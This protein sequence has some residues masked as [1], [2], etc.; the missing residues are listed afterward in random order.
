MTV[1]DPSS[2][3]ANEAQVPT[4]LP[5]QIK[6]GDILLLMIG[7]FIA[8][9]IFGGLL[10]AFD[11]SRFVAGIVSGIA[12]AVWC[13]VGYQR[14]SRSRGWDSL[15]VRFSSVNSKI[16]LWSAAGA[17]ALVALPA[18]LATLLQ[19][20]DLNLKEVPVLSVLPRDL[21]ELPL[22]IVFV[23]ILGPFSEELIFRGLLLDW[24]KQ[25]M[26]VW[27]A[28]LIISLLFALLHNNAFKSGII[29]WI[30]F[31]DRFLLG[32]ATSFLALRYRSLRPA[33]AMHA[34]LNGCVCIA[35]LF[36]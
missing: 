30:A 35:S 5:P 29:A 4:T 6:L 12:S 21:R 34:T 1:I 19:S 36:R 32:L 33:F 15:Q 27:P 3:P 7:A 16:I 20:A 28:A 25:K 17:I 31:S 24:L 13:I 14:L 10:F 26:A 18:L 2:P 8:A 22:A 9:L 11:A 23:V